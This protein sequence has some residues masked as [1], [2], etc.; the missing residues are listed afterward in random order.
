MK[1]RSLFILALLL[2]V[3]S[4]SAQIRFESGSLACVLEKAQTKHKLVFLDC[5]TT[6][7]GPCKWMD[8]NV[9]ANDT[10]A[11]FYNTHFISSKFD[12]EKGEGI[13]IAKRYDVRCFPTYLF[14][15]E[16]GVLI[17]RV[18]GAYLVAP[19]VAI[20]EKTSTPQTCFAAYQT[21]Y[22]TGKM[23]AKELIHYM[24]M[25]RACCLPVEEETNAFLATLSETEYL[26]RESWTVLRDFVSDPNTHSFQYLCSH[27]SAF[28]NRYTA[29]SVALV[30]ERVYR[31]AMRNTLF[32]K[33]PVDTLGYLK[34][35][36][37]VLAL[38]LPNAD[39]FLTGMDISYYERT[40]NWNAYAKTATRFVEQ[41]MPANDIWGLN[42]MAWAFYKQVSDTVYLAKALGWAKK[43]IDMHAAYANTDT[44]A[45]LLYTLG[46]KED[47]E[48]SAREAIRLAKI[49]GV[50]DVS[51]TEELLKKIR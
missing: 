15:D 25:K 2:L 47:A 48:K 50:S 29:D 14:L 31:G 51:G 34:L 22:E 6:W 5:Y 32:E 45:A 41:H 3:A 8:K 23:Q 43:S 12:M 20:G 30:I 38:K 13:E 46:R 39:R 16:K 21:Q 7:C 4:L 27:R 49:E 37:D 42:N 11:Q 36:S 28:E 9:F 26:N 24:N 17:H 33:K 18:S 19:F 44:Y 35:R 1:N 40:K 10:A